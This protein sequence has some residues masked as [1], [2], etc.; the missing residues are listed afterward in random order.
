LEECPTAYLVD[1]NNHC[2]R[3]SETILPFITLIAPL[4]FSIVIGI[5]YCQYRKTKPITAFIALQ[6]AFLAG[7]WFYQMLFLLKDGHNSSP[8]IVAFAI[9]CD[10]LIN[11]TFYEFLKTYILTG[12]DIFYTEY[13]DN[14]TRT[15]KAITTWSM[16]TSF[17]LFRFQY[18]G[19]FDK[20]RY[21]AHI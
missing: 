3:A 2:Y 12:E 13:R 17:Q 1:D 9:T 5:S 21:K 8:L 14:Y 7:F 4:I 15:S 19:L 16:V 20:D 18:C 11:C 10:Y 6:S